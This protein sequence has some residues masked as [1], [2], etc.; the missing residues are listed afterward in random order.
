MGALEGRVA[1]ITGSSRGI[2]AAIAVLFAKEGASV[3]LHGRDERALSRVREAIARD[4]P[5]SRTMVAI[6][7]VTRFDEIERM[8]MEVERALGPVDALVANAGGNPLR[9]GP[10]EDITESDWRTTIDGNLTATFLTLKSFLPGMKER[11]RGSI[12]TVSSAAAR[13][14]HAA[15][16]IAYA[17]AK[18]A[19]QI[20]TRDVALQA[21]PFGIRA[22]CL[23]PETI[24][25]ERNVAQIPGPVQAT[26]V[27]QHAVRRL[28]TPEDVAHAALYLAS[29]HSA[30]VSGVI[31][32]VAGGSVMV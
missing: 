20:L 2:G 26:L 13:R 7:D 30:W 12:I 3:A 32:D 11:Q 22:N 17:A 6:A 16:P 31:L 1:L 5:S 18:A 4:A 15:S 9:P 25:T 14:P 10:V 19:I 28:G 24:L 8:R 23:A 21:G 27:E 29:E